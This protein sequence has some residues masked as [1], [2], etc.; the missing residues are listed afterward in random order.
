MTGKITIMNNYPVVQIFPLNPLKR[1]LSCHE[2][3]PQQVNK[4]HNIQ[5]YV[6]YIP[7]ASSNISLRLQYMMFIL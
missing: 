5:V 4:T 6:Q 1:I 2:I 7:F 3:L